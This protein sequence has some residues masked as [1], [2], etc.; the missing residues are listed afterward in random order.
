MGRSSC[1][2]RHPQHL[3]DTPPDSNLTKSP[4]AASKEISGD[5]YI[6]QPPKTY[7][8]PGRRVEQSHDSQAHQ[9]E[10]R[11]SRIKPC[12]HD[13]TSCRRGGTCW[14]DGIGLPVFS[15]HHKRQSER[16][17]GN[18]DRIFFTVG[19][20]TE[21]HFRRASLTLPKP[22]GEAIFST[23]RRPRVSQ[24]ASTQKTS[25]RHT[26]PHIP[27]TDENDTH[28]RTDHSNG[29]RRDTRERTL[30]AKN[31]RSNRGQKN[32]VR[33][34]LTVENVTLN[35]KSAKLSHLPDR[36]AASTR[37]PFTAQ[38]TARRTRAS[39]VKPKSSGSGI[40]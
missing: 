12:V 32:P 16:L 3:P 25:G 17:P 20:D 11:P 39:G 19:I 9:H 34:E 4:S 15:K 40:E 33:P 31:K 7:C 23:S 28:V 38:A 22:P 6:N 27:R 29:A 26:R 8:P 5:N 35:A 36:R 1:P 24:E 18:G 37:Q 2:G 13:Q 21:R 30:E 14:D 10:S